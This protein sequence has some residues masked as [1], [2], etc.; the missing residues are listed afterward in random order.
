MV[1]GEMETEGGRVRSR[2]HRRVGPCRGGLLHGAF[3]LAIPTPPPQARSIGVPRTHVTTP[4][5]TGTPRTIAAAMAELRLDV[6]ADVRPDGLIA[7]TT[8]WLA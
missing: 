2:R 4:S 8:G 5:S 7:N 1:A 3:F 6:V